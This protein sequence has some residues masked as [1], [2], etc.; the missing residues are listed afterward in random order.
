MSRH[1]KMLTA[2]SSSTLQQSVE[3]PSSSITVII[4][5]IS[6]HTHVFPQK[7]YAALIVGEQPQEFVIALIVGLKLNVELREVGDGGEDDAPAVA[8]LV[9]QLLRQVWS[10]SISILTELQLSIRS[11][12]TSKNMNMNTSMSS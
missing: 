8:L 7:E 4:V 6:H 9:V 11:M 1:W 2:M 3:S 12:S 5:D 10:I